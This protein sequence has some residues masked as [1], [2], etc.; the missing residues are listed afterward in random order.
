[1]GVP[2]LQLLFIMD[3]S[4]IA[5]ALIFITY[6]GFLWLQ[7]RFQHDDYWNGLKNSEHL[8]EERNRLQKVLDAIPGLVAWIGSDSTFR[9]VNKTYAANYGGRAEDCLGKNITFRNP[10]EEFL[11]AVKTLMASPHAQTAREVKI[12]VRG[13]PRCHLFVLRKTLPTLSNGNGLEAYL[14]CIDIEDLREARA[15]L[16]KE[17]IKTEVASKLAALGEAAASTAHEIRNP[18]SV[19][20]NMSEL[21]LRRPRFARA[22][23]RSA[24][25]ACRADPDHGGPNR[26]DHRRSDQILEENRRR[27][28]HSR[29]AEP[30]DP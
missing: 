18:L 29:E 8:T 26:Q 6:Y 24:P 10:D 27:A 12:T 2:L 4:S 30:G 14:I 23:T 7:I 17:K 28:I 11:G 3:R 20:T 1:M 9:G 16:E 13:Q 19:I 21:M 22:P 5:M 25:K 15:E